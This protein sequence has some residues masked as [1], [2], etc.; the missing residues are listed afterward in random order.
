MLRSLGVFISAVFFLV[1]VAGFFVPENVVI[2][3]KGASSQNWDGHSYWQEPWGLSGVHKGIDIF[4]KKGQHV[5][6]ATD[7][8]VIY[9]GQFGIGGHVLVILGPKWRLH[10]YANLNKSFVKI[11][12]LVGSRYLVA[13]VGNSGNAQTKVPHLHY[14]VIS[15]FPYVWLWDGSKQ[16]WKKMFYLNPSD[17]LKKAVSRKK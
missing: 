13:E 7:G 6:S 15:L 14:S 2:P 12:N 1:I 11:G 17:Y 9:S 8:V 3:V 5:I 16:G 10:Y 4:A